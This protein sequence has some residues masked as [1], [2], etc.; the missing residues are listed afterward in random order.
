MLTVAEGVELDRELAI[1]V[2]DEIGGEDWITEEELI[3]MGS[4]F[5]D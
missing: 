1:F 4:L 3:G 2:G 5:S